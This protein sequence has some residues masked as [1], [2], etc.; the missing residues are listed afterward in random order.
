[1]TTT[2]RAMGVIFA[3]QRRAYKIVYTTEY[4]VVFD[5]FFVLHIFNT[6]KISLYGRVNERIGK[7]TKKLPVERDGKTTYYD[8]R[9]RG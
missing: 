4:F 1:M 6:R 2:K 9:K 7:K 8:G 3:L 5:G